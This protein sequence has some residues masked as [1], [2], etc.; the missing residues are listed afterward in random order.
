VLAAFDEAGTPRALPGG[1]RTVWHVNG[2]VFKPLDAPVAAI[3]WQG[4][5]LDRLVAQVRTAP[6][7]TAR[8]GRWVV[9]GWTAWR[10]ERGTHRPAAWPAVASAGRALHRALANL[11]A[12]EWLAARDDPW[13]RTERIAWSD[14]ELPEA[15]QDTP[16][17]AALADHRRPLDPATHRSQLI[18]TDLTDNV[19][20]APRTTPLVLD[21]SLSWRPTPYASAIV[22]ADAMLWEG[23]APEVVDR[24]ASAET[25]D[26]QEVFGQ[27]LLRAVI[28]RLLAARLGRSD[29]DPTTLHSEFAGVAAEAIRRC[30]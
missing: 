29:V 28:F 10:Y 12:P 16:L 18:H 8:D 11:A 20:F 24:V 22:A 3:A 23:A 14:E 7:R 30:S 5:I 4:R 13:A 15:V 27:F 21:L 2:T 6:P 17:L 1:Q 25:D 26:A 9:D 19:L